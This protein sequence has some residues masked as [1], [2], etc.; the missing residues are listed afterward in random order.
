MLEQWWLVALIGLGAGLL[1]G[2]LGVGGGLVIV[3][4]LVLAKKLDI[5]HAV[6]TSLAIIVPTAAVGA[7][8]HHIAGHVEWRYV[9]IVSL[10]AMVGGFFG[11]Q[12]AAS[13]PSRV[14]Q[15]IFAVFLVIVA[16]RMVISR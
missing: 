4:L 2:L 7:F 3:P 6:G 8:R 14:L 11:A 5:H 12:A 16:A 15:N 13:I 1:S 10:F 9:F